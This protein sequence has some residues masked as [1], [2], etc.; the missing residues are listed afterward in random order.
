MI[1][2]Y[3]GK[4]GKQAAF[5]YRPINLTSV[6]CEILERLFVQNLIEY[7]NDS[8]LLD[9]CQHD[10]SHGKSTVTNILECDKFIADH[11]NTSKAFDLI[12]ID[13]RRAFNQVDHSI[14]CVK[15][16]ELGIDGCYLKWVKDFLTNRKQYVTY[17]EACSN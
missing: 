10:F 13:F 11:L 15:L 8:E 7:L 6:A 5:S 2:I 16:K 14:L 1:P 4:G 12:S 3:R 17:K 9:H